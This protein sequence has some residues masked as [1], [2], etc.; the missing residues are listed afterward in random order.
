[1][2]CVA[3]EPLDTAGAPDQAVELMG[4]GI[5]VIDARR[6]TGAP[7]HRHVQF[8]VVRGAAAGIGPAAGLVM[9]SARRIRFPEVPYAR[10]PIE[11]L[12]DLPNADRRGAVLSDRP[13][14]L[15]NAAERRI[16]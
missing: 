14:T 9:P 10:R 11:E 5:V 3:Q 1:M 15:Q 6:E 4:D 8:E 12:A 13:A 16:P 2:L 7:V